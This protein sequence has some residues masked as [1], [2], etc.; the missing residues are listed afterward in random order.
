MTVNWSVV[1]FLFCL[2]I[3]GAVI[4]IKRLIYFLLQNNTEQLKKR[5]S[6]FALVQS[7]VMLLIMTIAGSVVSQRTGLNAPILE[8]LL[9]GKEGVSALIPILLPSILF[10]FSGLIIFCALY[11][12]LAKYVLDKQSVKAMAKLRTAIGISGCVLYG[13]ISEEIIA[14]WGLMNLVTFFALMFVQKSTVIIW[15]S[16][17]MSSF[18][19]ALGQFPTYIAAGCSQSRPFLYS[20]LVLSLSQS[21]LFGYLFWQYGLICCILAHMLFH[22]GWWIITKKEPVL[23]D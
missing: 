8:A 6:I 23:I 12:L 9:K 5:I 1:A 20:F 3:P 15:I 11:Q 16:L 19:F 21:L 7:V 22:L 2:S 14:R 17:F 10:S 18:I 4:A 13:G